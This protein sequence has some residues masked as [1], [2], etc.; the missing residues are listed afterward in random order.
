MENTKLQEKIVEEMEKVKKAREGLLEIMSDAE[1]I[2]YATQFALED[3][4]KTA[5]SAYQAGYELGVQD[6]Y[7]DCLEQL[8][9]MLEGENNGI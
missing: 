9:V 8:Y 3:D 1:R 5:K 6:G 7:M 4:E 2:G